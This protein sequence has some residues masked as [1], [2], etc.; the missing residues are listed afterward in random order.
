MKPNKKENSIMEEAQVL[1]SL[2]SHT[3]CSGAIKPGFQVGLWEDQGLPTAPLPCTE[4]GGAGK[5]PCKGSLRSKKLSNTAG[6]A[7]HGQHQ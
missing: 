4:L 5:A 6:A 7:A 1:L 3:S 2:L